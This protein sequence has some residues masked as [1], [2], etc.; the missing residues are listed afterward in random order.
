MVRGM[1]RKLANQSLSVAG[2]WQ[3]QQLRRLNIHEYQGAELM[4]KYGINVPKGVAVASLDE[5]KKAIQDVFP[6][7][8]EVVVKSQVLAGGRGLGTFKNGFQGGVHIVKADQ[9]EEIASKMLGQILVTKQTGAQG[10]VVSK[11]YLCEKMSLVN[12]MYFSIIL[13]RATAGPLIIACRKGGTSIEDLAEKFP[14]MIIKVPID[15][16]KGIS[17]ED[18]AKVVDGLA[19]KVADRNDSIEQVKKLYNLF[20]ETDCT[21]LEI[22][23]LA[24]TSDNKLVAADAKLNFDDNAAYR[25]KEIFSLRDSSQED[26]REVA[27]AKAD[28]NYIGLDGEIGCMVNGAGLAMAT[29]DIIK[30]HGGT[31]ANFLDV[32]GNA[33][34]GQVVEAFKILTADEK[35]KAILV[36]IF[37][38]IMKCDVIASGIVNAAKQVQLKVPVI[39]RL[40]GTNVEQ[41]KRILKES[42]MKLIT[43][44]DLDDAAE[45]A[46]KALA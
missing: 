23:P 7:Q 43:A 19:P 18:A 20:C 29:M 10:K 39:V 45:K 4:G 3:Q 17:D 25:Q 30:L 34:E 22:N 27:A 9:A 31:P 2:K 14:D 12:E 21:M 46:V 6:N 44:E 28:L 15:V 24:E 41:G 42:G 37:G 36:N 5:V 8:S 16:F 38:G 1:L 35:V 11:V 26:P 13:D 32:G 40:E 33:T